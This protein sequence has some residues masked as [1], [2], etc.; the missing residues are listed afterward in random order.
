[1]MGSGS[2]FGFEVAIVNTG[3]KSAVRKGIEYSRR[4]LG[5]T[6]ITTTQRDMHLDEL[7]LADAQH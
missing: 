7:E 6:N 5:Y 4:L 2:C 3:R 1:M